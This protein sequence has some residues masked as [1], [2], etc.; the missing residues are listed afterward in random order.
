MKSTDYIQIEKYL[1]GTATSQEFSA[2]EKRLRADAALRLAL[3]QEAGLE[4]QLRIL[5]KATADESLAPVV[6]PMVASE[7]NVTPFRPVFKTLTWRSAWYVVPAAA[8]AAVIAAFVLPLFHPRHEQLMARVEREPAKGPAAAPQKFTQTAAAEYFV[9]KNSTPFAEPVRTHVAL[10]VPPA[11]SFTAAPGPVQVAQQGAVLNRQV[12]V[13]THEQ[14]VRANNDVN[15]VAAQNNTPQIRPM[16]M[17]VNVVASVRPGADAV[18]N[19]FQPADGNEKKAPVVAAAVPAGSRKPAAVAVAAFGQVIAVNGK[20]TV[21]RPTEESKGR[22]I[23][24]SGEN[25]Q[26]GDVLETGPQSSI[27]LRLAEGPLVRLY[28]ETRLTLNQADHSTSLFLAAGAVD[29]RVQ[30]LVAGSSFSLSTSYVEARVLAGAEFRVMSDGNGSWVGV[31]LGRVQMV[32]SRA[33]GEVVV[34]EPGY[35]AAAARGLSPASTLDPV[36]RSKCL[37]F[38]GTGKYP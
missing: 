29:L 6:Q 23:T 25:I 18:P 32:R 19:V 1:D 22:Q 16:G 13:A 35:F 36:W 28:G 7:S 20:A 4:T 38:T 2:F 31:R 9:A 26:S 33:N 3:L 37:E 30:T 24:Q 34:L 10:P 14:P 21:L 5:L 27:T 11:N 15:V 17:P 12:A 8:A